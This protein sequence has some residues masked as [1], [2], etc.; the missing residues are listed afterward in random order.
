M[1]GSPMKEVESISIAELEMVN[2]RPA[3]G[4]RSRSVE[5]AATRDDILA[6]VSEVVHG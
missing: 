5:D 2:I 3:Q 4:N 1:K 6:I